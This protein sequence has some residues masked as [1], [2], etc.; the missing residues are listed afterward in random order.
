MYTIGKITIGTHIQTTDETLKLAGCELHNFIADNQRI[1]SHLNFDSPL[2]VKE[3][4]II[5]KL[6]GDIILISPD[7]YPHDSSMIDI[8]KEELA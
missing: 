2:D 3:Y 7:K 5:Q 6:S 4:L 8:F 1:E